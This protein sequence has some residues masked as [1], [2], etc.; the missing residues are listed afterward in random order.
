[1]PK[2]DLT[3]RPDEVAG[4]FDAIADRYDRMNAVMTF[5]QEQRWRRAV[6]RRLGVEPGAR[7]LDLAAGTG[8]S[9]VP[10]AEHGINVIA[11]DFSIGMLAVGQK[12]HPQLTFVAGDALRLPFADGVF[13]GVTISFGLRNVVDVPAALREM[14]RVTGPG[15]RLVV[16]ETSAPLAAPLRVGHRFYVNRVMPRIARIVTRSPEAYGYL[17]DSVGEWP[18]PHQLA[19][20]LTAAGWTGVGWRQLMFGAVAMHGA[21]KPAKPDAPHPAPSRT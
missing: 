9:S 5:G 14:A 6:R 13:D 4:M 18:G 3:R 2:A 11:C 10:F 16:L 15:G 12:Q 7:V 21:T 1:M 8:A 19:E 17:A 20:I